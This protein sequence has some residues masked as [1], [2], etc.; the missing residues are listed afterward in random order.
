MAYIDKTDL[1]IYYN[2][3]LLDQFFFGM[4]EENVNLIIQTI[5]DSCIFEVRGYLTQRWINEFE[6][7]GADRNP[8][9]VR[10]ICR[11]SLLELQKRNNNSNPP[12]YL[13]EERKQIIEAL[14]AYV[15]GY[16]D[17]ILEVAEGADDQDSMSQLF[18]TGVFNSNTI[19]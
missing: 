1:E 19:Y 3:E 13:I 12:E 4:N 6:K 16:Q 9:F 18:L 8:M 14:K 2:S 5:A 11:L 7:T 17:P 15:K 10:Y